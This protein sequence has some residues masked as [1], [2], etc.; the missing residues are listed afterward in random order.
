MRI[1]QI[2]FWSIICSFSAHAKIVSTLELKTNKIGN[3]LIF[4]SKDCPC[5]KGNLSYINSLANEFS[6]FNFVAIHSKKNVSNE[7]VQKY[8]Q[9]KNL[10]FDI[11]NDSNLKIADTYKALKT[12]HAFILKGDSVVYNG[13]ITNTTM[14]ENAKE[15]YLRDA[16]LSIKATGKPTKSETRTLGCFISR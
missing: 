5:S 15:F 8:L 6:E 2:I 12:P 13:G 11:I 4:I 14:P 9:D 3:V 16:L 7:E 1:I 10:S